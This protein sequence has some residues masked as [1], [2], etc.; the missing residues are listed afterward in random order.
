MRD[1]L[2]TELLNVA[3]QM[4]R[5]AT[6]AQN[7]GSQGALD[8]VQDA[9][10]RVGDAWSGSNFGYHACIYY[11]GLHSPPS[12]A[13]WSAEWGTYQAFY[14]G[15]RG[16]W[17]EFKWEDV[18]KAI[19]K[20]A[21][22]PDFSE[23]ERLA[24]QARKGFETGRSEMRSI[25]TAAQTRQPDP[26]LAEIR[27]DLDKVMLFTMHD[28]IQVQLPHGSF[29]SRDTLALSGGIQ[30]A[31]HQQVLARVNVARSAFHACQSL[32][33]LTSAASSHLARRARLGASQ[34]GPAEDGRV[35]IGH[36]RSLLWRELKDFIE[37]R[38]GKPT[39]EFNRV[40][41]AGIATT[42]R[43]AQMLDTASMAF[44][45]LTAED[46]RTDGGAVARQNVIHEA[47]LFQARLG[48]QRAIILIEEGCGEFSN[49]HGLGQIRFP[50]GKIASV[51]EEVRQVVE[52]EASAA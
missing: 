32:V 28:A 25:L 19:Y 38:L 52:R 45:V 13:H 41:P 3:D 12:G 30:P 14:G 43:L 17:R 1:S 6:A 33:E 35:F 47:G 48:F 10:N 31:P 44:L 34:R 50:S 7:T 5:L 26:R 49:I 27:V 15:S 16:D 40:S 8:R 9:A 23:I 20:L 21:G 46:E 42:E 24:D 51:F 22:N 39:D 37:G 4:S 2:A 29:M 18:T 36:G 11:A